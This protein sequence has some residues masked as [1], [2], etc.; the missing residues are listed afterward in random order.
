MQLF[1]A[2]L[3]FLRRSCREL[4]VMKGRRNEKINGG[5]RRRLVAQGKLHCLAKLTLLYVYIC[6]VCDR[7]YTSWRVKATLRYR[8]NSLDVNI[9][10]RVTSLIVSYV[11]HYGYRSLLV[12]E[13]SPFLKNHAV[14]LLERY[15]Y[16]KKPYAFCDV[17]FDKCIYGD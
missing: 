11:F 13:N 4:H 5:F 10:I 16:D 1:K 17:C 9:A 2:N 15:Y 8:F 6:Y 12:A 7:L 3:V 14:S